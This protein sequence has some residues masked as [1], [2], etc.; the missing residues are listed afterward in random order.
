MHCGR[1]PSR[2]CTCQRSLFVLPAQRFTTRPVVRRLSFARFALPV[3]RS[4]APHCLSFAPLVLARAPRLWPCAAKALVLSRPPPAIHGRPPSR[5]GQMSCCFASLRRA[6]LEVAPQPC[7]QSGFCP[8]LE[9]DRSA[10]PGGGEGAKSAS[11]AHG[12]GLER[13]LS[14]PGI[15]REEKMSR[16]HTPSARPS[17]T[18]DT[19]QHQ[20][21]KKASPEFAFRDTWAIFEG[22]VSGDGLSTGSSDARD[23]RGATGTKAGTRGLKNDSITTRPTVRI[24][25]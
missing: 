1:R 21:V 6:A 11:A 5:G 3:L 10:G 7:L 13:E 8:H 9:G 20:I 4:F 17:R 2:A 12:G 18:V 19:T 22:V 25:A 23:V 14:A 24:Q 15:P 16:S